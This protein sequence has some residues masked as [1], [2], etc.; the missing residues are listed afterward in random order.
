MYN[1]LFYFFLVN[2]SISDQ[3]KP[4]SSGYNSRTRRSLF[5]VVETALDMLSMNL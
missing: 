5:K 4:S 2:D 3:D 1:K